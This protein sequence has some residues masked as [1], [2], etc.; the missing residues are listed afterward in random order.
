MVDGMVGHGGVDEGGAVVN[1]MVGHGGVDEGGSVVDSVVGSVGHRGVGGRGV[2]DG[3]LD[4]GLVGAGHALVL[5]VGVVLLVLVH[6]VVHDLRAAVRQ[7]DHVLPLDGV[8]CPGL[9]PRVLVGVAVVVHTVHV[10]P[11]LVVVGNLLMVG[12]GVGHR[13]H[14]GG[15]CIGCWCCVHHR[16]DVRSRGIGGRRVGRGGGRQGAVAVGWSLGGEGTGQGGGE[17][18]QLHG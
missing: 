1:C 5:H 7:V 3:V 12:G 14:I 18:E 9:V 4:E 11:E 17:Q 2:D 10:V 16:G 6:E 15:W 13:G 8:A